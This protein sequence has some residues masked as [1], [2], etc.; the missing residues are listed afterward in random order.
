[1]YTYLY[2]YIYISHIYTCTQKVSI[3]GVRFLSCFLFFSGEKVRCSHSG[4]KRL[5]RTRALLVMSISVSF[6]P[7]LGV[8]FLWKTDSGLFKDAFVDWFWVTTKYG[9]RLVAV[10]YTWSSRYRV[11]KAKEQSLI[12][13]WLEKY[14]FIFCN[15]LLSCS[16]AKHPL[17]FHP[18]SR[19][20]FAHEKNLFAFTI[21]ELGI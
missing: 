17:S 2:M 21:L 10:G 20:I 11:D 15:F 14:Y 18:L 3:L 5:P 19:G 8:E 13:Y 4:P 1:M 6:F 12:N 7:C 9:V 16:S